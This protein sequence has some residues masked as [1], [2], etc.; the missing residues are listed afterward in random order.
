MLSRSFYWK[1]LA[2]QAFPLKLRD[3][4][5]FG[6]SLV[7]LKFGITSRFLTLAKEK[8]SMTPEALSSLRLPDW[9]KPGDLRTCCLKMFPACSRMTKG[10]R[11]LSSSPRWMSWGIM[12]SGQCLTA[13]IS[14]SPNQGS[15][16]S[17]SA[18]LIPDAPEKYFLSSEMTQKLLYKSSAGRRDRESTTRKG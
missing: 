15:G 7:I 5:F 4:L 11:L 8:D 3:I 6:I 10:G 16:C 13:P 17:L 2:L 12:S 18:I 9:L 14:T 1:T